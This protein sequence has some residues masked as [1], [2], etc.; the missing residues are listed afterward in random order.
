MPNGRWVSELAQLVAKIFHVKFYLDNISIKGF[1]FYG[2]Q[3]LVD[4]ACLA[5][6]M[7]CNRTIHLSR[8]IVKKQD[9][10]FMLKVVETMCKAH[11]KEIHESRRNENL[12]LRRLR[13]QIVYICLKIA[14][15]VADKLKVTISNK[16]KRVLI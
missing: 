14:D 12:E 7:G 6:E 4:I 10:N 11:E 1:V 13:L 5:F 9:A 8:E 2:H 3:D 16:N 15:K